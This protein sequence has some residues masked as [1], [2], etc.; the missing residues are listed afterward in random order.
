MKTT[1][2]LFVATFSL[3]LLAADSIVKET[4]TCKND[5]VTFSA[6][7]TAK[8]VKAKI[9]TV[10]AGQETTMELSPGQTSLQNGLTTELTGSI[11]EHDTFDYTATLVRSNEEDFSEDGDKR[12]TVKAQLMLMTNMFIDCVGNRVAA[13][14]VECTVVIDRK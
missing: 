2:A 8:S 14:L 10:Y 6:V 12:S 5:T 3:S 13:D 4:W 9:E 11:L 1:L 7:L